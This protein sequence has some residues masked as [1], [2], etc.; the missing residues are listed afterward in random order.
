M[1]DEGKNKIHASLLSHPSS[2]WSSY[3]TSESKGSKDIKSS[4]ETPSA[5]I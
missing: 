1:N 2:M 3:L 5:A 4:F